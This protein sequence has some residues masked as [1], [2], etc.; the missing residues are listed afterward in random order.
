MPYWYP[1]YNT[2]YL[3]LWFDK[4]Y[5]CKTIC[6]SILLVVGFRS[7]NGKGGVGGLTGAIQVI[8]TELVCCFPIKLLIDIS[9]VYFIFLL[10]GI[11]IEQEEKKP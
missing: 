9:T 3:R 10:N 6:D 4:H 11:E 7:S 5:N 2:F 8:V 1:L